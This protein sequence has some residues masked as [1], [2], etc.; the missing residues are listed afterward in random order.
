MATMVITEI[1]TFSLDITSLLPNVCRE[2]MI[3]TSHIL[4]YKMVTN[5]GLEIAMVKKVEERKQMNN[6]TSIVLKM[7]GSFVVEITEIVS[8]K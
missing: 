4:D 1:L 5:A 8:T 3:K 2:L 7:M 6:V